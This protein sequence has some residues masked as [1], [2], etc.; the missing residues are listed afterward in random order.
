M[1]LSLQ[2]RQPRE[3]TNGTL[4]QCVVM[5]KICPSF[6]EYFRY[7]PQLLYFSFFN[8]QVMAGKPQYEMEAPVDFSQIRVFYMDNLNIWFC[9]KVH[10]EMRQAL[11]KVLKWNRNIQTLIYNLVGSIF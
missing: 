8:A 1:V 9:E 6:L 11:K 3:K 4:A 7:F 10:N 5:L 2:L